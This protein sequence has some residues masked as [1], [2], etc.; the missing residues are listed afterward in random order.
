M[1]VNIRLYN[2]Q[3]DKDA[4]WWENKALFSKSKLLILN[5]CLIEK[6]F[7]TWVPAYEF[8]LQPDALNYVSLPFKTK[9]ITFQ[10]QW[11]GFPFL[12]ILDAQVFFLTFHLTLNLSCSS[13][14]IRVKIPEMTW[15]SCYI[16]RT[17]FCSAGLHGVL[18]ITPALNEQVIDILGFI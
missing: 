14:D 17:M 15:T 8:Q 18:V 11:L 10:Q 5:V 2:R 9:A 6:L 13:C 4:V 7:Q 16:S 1:I 12:S 3:T